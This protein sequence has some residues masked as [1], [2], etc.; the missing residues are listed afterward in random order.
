MSKSTT[1]SKFTAEE[2]AKIAAAIKAEKEKAKQA[3]I[4]AEIR[5]RLLDIQR[6]QPG[7]RGY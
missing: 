3:E 4:D 1:T 5:N 7:Y 6:T 2:E